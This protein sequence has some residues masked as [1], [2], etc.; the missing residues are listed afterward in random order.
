MARRPTGKERQN[1][2]SSGGRRGPAKKSNAAVMVSA[3]AVV[4]IAVVAVVLLNSKGDDKKN[5]AKLPAATPEAGLKADPAND[6]ANQA[7]NGKPSAKAKDDAPSKAELKPLADKV[8]M[9]LWN[10]IEVHFQNARRLKAEAMDVQANTAAF[11]KKM[12]EA[13][14]EWR[15]GDLKYEDWKYK[16]DALHPKLIDTWFKKQDKAVTDATKEF[17]GW[18][19]YEGH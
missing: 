6:F 8:D 11:E 1:S 5:Q 17:R 2:R 14:G 10:E 15:K 4:V 18:L 16:V 9:T 19:K 13:V 3:L 7:G 12:G